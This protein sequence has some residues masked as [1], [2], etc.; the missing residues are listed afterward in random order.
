M[1]PSF[2]VFLSHSRCTMSFRQYATRIPMS[3]RI[4]ETP[5]CV[6]AVLGAQRRGSREKRGEKK[7]K[8]KRTTRSRS[9]CDPSAR[10]KRTR[11]RVFASTVLLPR[12]SLVDCLRIIPS[13]GSSIFS[14]HGAIIQKPDRE[15]ERETEGESGG[16]RAKD[17]KQRCSI[18][19]PGTNAR[20]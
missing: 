11:T 3:S 16:E 19:D 17:G 18:S 12:L 14:G 7:R 8:G 20:N 13:R 6:S 5:V 1:H 9:P 10:W 2:F 4:N 15:R